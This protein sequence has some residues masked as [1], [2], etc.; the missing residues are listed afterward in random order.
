MKAIIIYL[1]SIALLCFSYNSM[2]ATTEYY[3]CVTDRGT[4]FSEFP[5]GS[6]AIKHKIQVTDPDLQAPKNFVKEL[7]ELERLQIIR[8]IEAEIRS[9]KYRLDILSRNRDRAQYQQEQRLNRI[10]SDKE[11]KQISKDIKKQLK[12]INKQ[13][14]RDVKSVNKK[15]AKLE[16]K[17]ARYN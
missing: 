16:K 17:L 9:Y 6:R 8:N 2:A 4:I 12:A 11:A 1:I 14:G 7:N 15:L 10:L 5:C 13:Y 3:K